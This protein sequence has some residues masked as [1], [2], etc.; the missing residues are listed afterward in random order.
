[1]S[2]SQ[3]NLKV[4]PGWSAL[5]AKHIYPVNRKDNYHQKLWN[6]RGRETVLNEIIIAE[7]LMTLTLH[8]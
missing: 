7:T 4:L 2:Q 5:S 1:M 3:N 6:R 8:S